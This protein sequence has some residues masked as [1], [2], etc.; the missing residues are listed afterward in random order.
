[1]KHRKYQNVQLS[2]KETEVVA[3]LETGSNNF[4]EAYY[5]Y[6]GR[7]KRFD[8]PTLTTATWFNKVIA[9]LH[10]HDI[11]KEIPFVLS[12]QKS[13]FIWQNPGINASKANFECLTLHDAFMEEK[14]ERNKILI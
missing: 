13:M 8:R 6:E 10:K 11:F 14:S 3:F 12:Y 4:W 2:K 1:M 9:S 7:R 5:N